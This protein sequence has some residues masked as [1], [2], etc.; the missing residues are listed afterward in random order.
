MFER[1]NKQTEYSKVSE[2]SQKNRSMN[3]CNQNSYPRGKSVFLV[4]G[5]D[6]KF[7]TMAQLT[8]V[9]KASIGG[10]YFT[11]PACIYLFIYIWFVCSKVQTTGACLSFCS[12]SSAQRLSFPDVLPA[13]FKNLYPGRTWERA[14]N[15]CKNLICRA[16]NVE[17]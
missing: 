7:H 3:P 12:S 13:E 11:L 15:G 6:W 8:K 17:Y 14:N 4:R 5:L 10:A 9:S 16:L 2:Y 1:W